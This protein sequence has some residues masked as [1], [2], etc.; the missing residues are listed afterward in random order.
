MNFDRFS[1]SK[2]LLKT[3]NFTNKT[4]FCSYQLFLENITKVMTSKYKRMLGT[5]D[6]DTLL[7]SKQFS[8]KGNFRNKAPLPSY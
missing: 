6:F 3:G 4:P 7:H 1:H 8:K 2:Q 5:V